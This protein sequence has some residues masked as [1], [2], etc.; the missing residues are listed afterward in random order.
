MTDK[1]EMN[2]A[3]A[4]SRSN[5]RLE[6][7]RFAALMLFLTAAILECVIAWA[8]S[9]PDALIIPAGMAWGYFVLPK[10]SD[11]LMDWA[12]SNLK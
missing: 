2:H 7:K 5:V 12:T 6:V 4:R 3:F 11:V 9:L 8:V 10:V 1:Q